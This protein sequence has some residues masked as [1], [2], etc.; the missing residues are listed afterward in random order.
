M[1]DE[2]VDA[3]NA[4]IAELEATVERLRGELRQAKR[5]LDDQR[6]NTRVAIKNTKLAGRE[7]AEAVER[8]GNTEEPEIGGALR[9]Y[10]KQVDE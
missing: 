2:E 10:R 4:R 6:H 5:A 1:R 8:F 9:R 7:L 3:L